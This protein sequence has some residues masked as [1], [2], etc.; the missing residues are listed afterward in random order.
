MLHSAANNCGF[1]PAV[2]GGA[3]YTLFVLSKG[4]LRAANS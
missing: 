3:V 2:T 1:E 4:L